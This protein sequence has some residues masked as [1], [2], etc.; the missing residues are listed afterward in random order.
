MVFHYHTFSR[1]ISLRM[2][3]DFISPSDMFIILSSELT[4]D[5]ASQKSYGS[6][7]I[8]NLKLHCIATVM[9]NPPWY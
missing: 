7:T 5:L 6:V 4:N 1:A 2:M 3:H 8:P 9:K